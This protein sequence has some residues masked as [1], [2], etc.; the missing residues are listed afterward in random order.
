MDADN[1]RARLG[2]MPAPSLELVRQRMV[3]AEAEL[4]AARNAMRKAADAAGI[5]RGGLFEGSRFI[6]RTSGERW[7]ASRSAAPPSGPGWIHEIKHDGFRIMARRDARGVRLFSRNSYNR[8]KRRHHSRRIEWRLRTLNVPLLSDSDHWRLHHRPRYQRAATAERP[9][10][11][12][13]FRLSTAPADP[14]PQHS[15]SY[16]VGASAAV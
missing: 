13:R 16:C 5:K 7:A 10:R 8:R 2:L 6:E 14:W 3:K 4:E 9:K 12:R 11:P 15:G 1:L